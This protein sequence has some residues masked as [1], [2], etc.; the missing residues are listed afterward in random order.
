MPVSASNCILSLCLLP[1]LTCRYS[2]SPIR[3]CMPQ[4]KLIQGPFHCNV[5][6]H[7]RKSENTICLQ[8]SFIIMVV[9][10]KH[11]SCYGTHFRCI[12]IG[13]PSFHIRSHS[14]SNFFFS[15][16]DILAIIFFE[17]FVRFSNHPGVLV[18]AESTFKTD[19]ISFHTASCCVY[20]NISVGRYRPGFITG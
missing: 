3:R 17:A 10:T 7:R 11:A 4:S 12:S 19:A 2:Y 8:L 9:N 20:H 5:A 1:V 14:S 13:S 18:S 6:S 16:A 15:S